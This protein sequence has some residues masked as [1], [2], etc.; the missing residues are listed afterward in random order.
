[1][2]QLFEFKDVVESRVLWAIEGI[3][4]STDVMMFTTRADKRSMD[5]AF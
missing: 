3:I 4:S 2:N 5:E 1:M